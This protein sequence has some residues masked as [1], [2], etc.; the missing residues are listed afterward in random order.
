MALSV[1]DENFEAEVLNPTPLYWLIF[2]LNGVA[3]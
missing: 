1:S 2:G 3:L